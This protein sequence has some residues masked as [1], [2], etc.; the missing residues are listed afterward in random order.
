MTSKTPGELL[1]DSEAAL[2][3]VDS[4]IQDMGD[5]ATPATD[6]STARPG[7]GLS[8]AAQI[9]ERG[10]REITAVLDSLR[11]SRSL[12]ERAT[13]DKLSH[14]GS[15]LREV[16]SATETAATDILNGIDRANALVDG[17]DACAE[18]DDREQ[19]AALRANLRDELFAVMG[20]MQFQ[21][22][23]AQQLAYASAVLDEVEARLAAIAH[24]FEVPHASKPA[25][26]LEAPATP[27]TFDPNAT[28]AG[29]EERQAT[30]DEIIAASH[31][32]H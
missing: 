1:Y 13:L 25:E 29:R 5:S 4:A 12:L 15:K 26:G 18:T 22:I 20:H 19:A 27:Q 31:R 2:R 3:L 21:D 28:T 14:T 16:S 30:A 10:Y 23:T 6:V 24:A 11:Q 17:L 7:A 9:L 8:A 32:R